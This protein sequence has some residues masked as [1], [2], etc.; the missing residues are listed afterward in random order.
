ME[1]KLINSRWKIFS[2]APLAGLF[3][4]GFL[5]S[6]VERSGAQDIPFESTALTEFDAPQ[7]F[8]D[9]ILKSSTPLPDE[10]RYDPPRLS[11]A[12]TFDFTW[13]APGGSEGFGISDF[14]VHCSCQWTLDSYAEPIVV[15]PGAA[16]HLW[17]GPQVLDLPPRVYD[18]YLDL[19]WR[20][21]TRERWG[22]TG[23]MTP[24]F[25]GDFERIDA[26]AFQFTGWLLADVT[27]GEHWT[28]LGGL[29]YIRQLK[30]NLLPIGGLVWRPHDD[31]RVE[32]VVPRP[33]I[34]HR[35]RSD[36]EREAWVYVSGAFGGGAW[37]ID[38]GDE[39]V[40]LQYSDFRLASGV[41]WLRSDGG[42]AVLE[43]GYVFS[44]DISVD[45][46][47]LLAPDGTAFVHLNLSF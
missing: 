12:P 38:D 29:A 26:D 13:L 4:I 10:T 19:S 34:A 44:R 46:F 33:R 35:F 41:E 28:A 20:M 43:I 18:L 25:Y 6:L 24:G 37:A 14:D 32:A 8:D 30:S 17:S 9:S 11:A 39:N 36:A 21:I 3:A 23:G 45:D 7:H 15:T 16:L 5:L 1:K 47:S 27:L 22:L 42:S 31:W 40:L 2:S